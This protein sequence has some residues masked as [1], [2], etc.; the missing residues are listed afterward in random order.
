[1]AEIGKKN[2]HPWHLIAYAL[3]YL[4]QVYS[5]KQSMVG[6]VTGSGILLGS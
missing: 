4:F 1:M 2:M 3:G 5:M 6:E